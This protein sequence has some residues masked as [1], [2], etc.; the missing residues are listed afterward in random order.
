[1]SPTI[2]SRKLLYSSLQV[3]ALAEGRPLRDLPELSLQVWA[4]KF[5]PIVER[6][7]EQKHALVKR[8]LPHQF[9]RS[10]PVVS[11]ANRLSEFESMVVADHRFL[12]QMA[13]HLDSL[14]TAKSIAEEFKMTRHPQFAHMWESHHT[15]YERVTMDAFYHCLVED[16]FLGH[17]ALKRKQATHRQD[18]RR[19][20][21]KLD[22]PTERAGQQQVIQDHFREAVREG[23]F[24]SVS[25]RANLEPGSWVGLGLA[26]FSSHITRSA[27]QL[28]LVPTLAMPQ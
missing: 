23:D 27:N 3:E 15:A 5:V 13:D 16:Q 22:V 11:L 8:N 9:Q 24:I 25:I 7:I 28:D 4:L 14:R 2:H 21:Q 10:A 19:V 12:M 17:K 18:Q 20:R 26:S 6:T 1:M